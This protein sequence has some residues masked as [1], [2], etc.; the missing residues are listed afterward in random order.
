MR[1]LPNTTSG[2]NTSRIRSRGFTSGK[3]SRTTLKIRAPRRG[4]SRS[5]ARCRAHR[6]TTPTER[7]YPEDAMKHR[8][9]VSELATAMERLEPRFLL[10]GGRAVAAPDAALAVSDPLPP[11]VPGEFHFFT[12]AALTT[13]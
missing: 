9:V 7:S 11:A 13:P 5:A 6:T 3:P 1:K 10:S 12:D 4:R 8:V 2:W